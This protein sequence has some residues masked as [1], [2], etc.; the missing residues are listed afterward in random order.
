LRV[1]ARRGQVRTEKVE[2]EEKMSAKLLVRVCA[3]GMAGVAFTV[4]P[5]LAAGEHHT[6]TPA[7]KVVWQPAP[8]AIPAGVGFAVLHGN[9]AEQ[10]L[11]VIRLKFPAGFEA[12]P[13]RHSNEEH[14]TIISGTLGVGTGETLS[15]EAAPLLAAGSF[16]Q[17][18]A[19]M[20]HFAW[21]DQETVL[22]INGMGP[23]DVTYVNPEDDPRNKQAGSD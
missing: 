21:T 22:Q 13:H 2:Q 12:P 14:V 3:I 5:A 9:P 7:D 15:R 8:P 23:F 4:L 16:I 20:A 11:F 10:G 1:Q 19:N 6:A 18:P 17:M